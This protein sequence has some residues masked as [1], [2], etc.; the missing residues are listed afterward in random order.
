MRG[1]LFKFRSCQPEG[2]VPKENGARKQYL[3][4]SLFAVSSNCIRSAQH[5]NTSS[6]SAPVSLQDRPTGYRLFTRW[7]EIAGGTGDSRE[8]PP[9]SGIVRHDSHVRK[10]GVSRPGIEPGSPWWEAVPAPGGRSSSSPTASPSPS[11]RARSARWLGAGHPP[12]PTHYTVEKTRNNAGACG[13]MPST[14]D[15]LNVWCVNPARLTGRCGPPAPVRRRRRTGFGFAALVSRI[16]ALAPGK[17]DVRRRGAGGFPRG[18]AA[19]P[20]PPHPYLVTP[21]PALDT[22]TVRGTF[23]SPGIGFFVFEVP[24]HLTFL[25]VMVVVVVRVLAYDRGNMG[26]ISGLVTP[27][28]SHVWYCVVRCRW[29]VGFLRDLPFSLLLHSSTA[30]YSPCFILIALKTLLRAIQATLLHSISVPY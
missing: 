16:L 17:R 6:V 30:P 2:S 27:G 23:P 21:S 8:N 19:S 12:L 4:Y 28:F 22:S 20:P 24:M 25:G 3:V 9:T 13:R 29:S 18:T 11:G 7:D 10:S 26:F 1:F 5:D 15:T 14:M